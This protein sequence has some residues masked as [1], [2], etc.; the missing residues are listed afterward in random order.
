MPPADLDRSKIDFQKYYFY[1]TVLNVPPILLMY[2]MR[3]VRLLQQ[4]KSSVPVS[5][6]IFTVIRDVQQKNGARA[7]FAG[8]TVFSLGLTTTKILQFA[9]YDYMAQ[10]TKEN[11][12]FEIEVL[13]SPS[14]LSGVLGTISAVVTTFFVVPFD[15]VTKETDKCTGW[16]K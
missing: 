10:K 2:P 4:R 6:S 13:K 8:A 7:L 5:S 9:T 1:G 14:V 11:D 3:T 12:Y 16:G 15:M